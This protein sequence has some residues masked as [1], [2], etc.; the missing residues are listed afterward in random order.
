MRRGVDKES[1]AMYRL[2]EVQ[3]ASDRLANHEKLTSAIIRLWARAVGHNHFKGVNQIVGISMSV[4]A[5]IFSTVEDLGF[6]GGRFHGF[7]RLLPVEQ[8]LRLL[9]RLR[10]LVL[11]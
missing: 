9:H 8:G 2:R 11:V 6:V 3:P 5:I 10:R 4:G 1:V 7:G